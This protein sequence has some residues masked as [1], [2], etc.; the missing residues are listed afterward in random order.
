M[1]VTEEYVPNTF[2]LSINPKMIIIPFVSTV[3]LIMKDYFND[4]VQA[5]RSDC[6]SVSDKLLDYGNYIIP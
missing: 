5:Q 4:F 2:F 1:Y 3:I 6:D